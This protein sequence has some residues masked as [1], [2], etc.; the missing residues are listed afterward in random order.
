MVW[1]RHL[2]GGGPARKREMRVVCARKRFGRQ[3]EAAEGCLGLLGLE[4]ASSLPPL[5]HAC[6]LALALSVFKK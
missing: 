2:G 4:A 1:S 6:L 5:L 3:S